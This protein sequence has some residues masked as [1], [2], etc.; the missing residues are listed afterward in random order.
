[1][2]R[3]VYCPLASLTVTAAADQDIWEL[4]AGANNKLKLLGWEVNS[5]ATASEAL[6]LRIVRGTA[7]GSGGGTGIEVLSDVDDGA[8][9]AA[10]ETLNT[11][12]GTDGDIIQHFG[13]EQIGPLGMVYTPEMQIVVG[14][15]TWLKLNLITQPTAFECNGWICWEE[16]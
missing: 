1:M 4:V 6:E 3:I 7:S 9:T 2:G 5:D 13:W 10:V 14:E 15:G 16:I 11:T 8:I 12:P